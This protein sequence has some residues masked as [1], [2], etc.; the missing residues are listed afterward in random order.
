MFTTI[1]DTT[2]F[3]FRRC[4]K[5]KQ[6]SERHILQIC[7]FGTFVQFGLL[8]AQ[9]TWVQKIS[10]GGLGNPFC[11]NPLNENVLYGAV[12]GS[13]M[14]I[15]RDRGKTWHLFSN[16]GGGPIKSIAVS[17]RDTNVIL[18]AQE[19]GPPDRIMKSTNNGAT[20][21]QTFSGDFYYWGVPLVYNATTVNDT[22]YTMGSNTIYR[23]TNFGT[24][25]DS[26]R[27]NPFSSSNQGWEFALLR[28]DS[29]NII[30][31]A[32]N[33]NGIWKSTDYGAQWRRVHVATGEVP[34]MALTPGN[35]MIVY[36]ARWSG[37]GG[38][39]KSTDGGETWNYSTPLNSINM[40]GVSVARTNPNY[41]ITGTYGPTFATNGGI[42]ISRNAGTTW[43]RTYLNMV[44]ALNYAC[45]VLDTLSV[46]A[47][48]G[49]G[50]WK[51]TYPAGNVTVVSPNGDETWSV[52]SVHNITWTHA[53]ISAVNIDYSTNN[54][55]AWSSIASNV[56]ATGG[57]YA[58]T[59]PNIPS[60]QCRVR[61]RDVGDSTVTDQSDTTFTI[62]LS[63]I[64]VTSPNGGEYLISGKLVTILWSSTGVTTVK[65][66]YSIDNGAHWLLIRSGVPAW[67]GSS[68]W[69]VP[70]SPSSLCKIRI[71]D[72]DNT[73]FYDES[74]S[75]FTIHAITSFSSFIECTDNGNIRDTLIFQESAGATDS[76][77][78]S[79]GEIELPARPGADTFDVRWRIPGSNGSKL[80]VC[81]TV[82]LFSPSEIFTAELQAGPGGYPFTIR[83][84][85]ETFPS[86]RIYL[87]DELT[88]GATLL[89]D[90]NVDSVAVITGPSTASI[91]IVH[92]YMMTANI[93]VKN[94]WK[95]IS[96]PVALEDS[97]KNILFPTS[98]S[99]A[100][101]YDHGYAVRETLQCGSGYWLKFSANEIIPI[102]GLPSLAETVSVDK[103]WNIIGS[104]SLPHPVALITTEP[105][106]IVI[107][108]YFRFGEGYVSSDTLTPGEGYWVKVNQGGKI[109]LKSSALT[110]TR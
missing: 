28:P 20:W 7:L 65:L 80:N 75:V 83:W 88:A 47:L 41:L 76:L 96:L 45:L 43:E 85:S 71:T 48:Q 110:K 30:L 67:L 59:I 18:A 34:A 107:S 38:L 109:I 2:M 19:A 14:H 68:S 63:A 29:T 15:S 11:V 25:W 104:L 55:A 89:V 36:A 4:R 79:F 39:V 91:Q 50:I 70:H 108:Q 86:G 21:F 99:S 6:S 57:A 64:T 27:S 81:D 101:V 12:G 94:G 13:N 78:P 98:K 10:G 90:M 16:L 33:A 46:F 24:T 58:W 102:T 97:R 105:S 9:T 93:P 49:D 42:Y 66:E 87:R 100:Y 32:D 103:G 82:G 3:W 92:Q 56:P 95:L 74:E 77:D 8:F 51:L 44:N 5:K 26:V 54:G 1:G 35:P 73:L 22:V 40:W 23:S 17:V 106:S 52:N 69:M 53:N 37:G 61:V 31:A 60:T 62:L 84:D 72:M